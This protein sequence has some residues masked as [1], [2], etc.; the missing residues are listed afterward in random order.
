LSAA[1]FTAGQK[2][3]ESIACAAISLDTPRRRHYF[4]KYAADLRHGAITPKM[5]R[6]SRAA[7]LLPLR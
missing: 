6:F 7:R 3:A 1:S 5:S 4:C 2:L